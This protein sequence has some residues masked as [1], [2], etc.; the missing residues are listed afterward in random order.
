LAKV[1]FQVEEKH[2]DLKTA[3]RGTIDVE[4]QERTQDMPPRM[5]E[6]AEPSYQFPWARTQAVMAGK[7]ALHAGDVAGGVSAFAAAALRSALHVTKSADRAL[8]R[9]LH[10]KMGLRHVKKDKHDPLPTATWHT[11]VFSDRSV[12]VLTAEGGAIAAEVERTARAVGSLIPAHSMRTDEDI[13]SNYLSFFV[14]VVDTLVSGTA[15]A[16]FLARFADHMREG[17]TSEGPSEGGAG[18]GG[19]SAAA[20]A[21]DSQEGSSITAGEWRNRLLE[22]LRV[23]LERDIP[24]D[25]S[26]QNRIGGGGKSSEWRARQRVRTLLFGESGHFRAKAKL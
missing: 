14:A 23:H 3:P 26:T 19:T 1:S 24:N 25:Y 15:Q 13:K 17:G 12:E 9:T 11:T 21:S 20:A 7:E 4:A 2:P 6:A 18:G 5:T 10:R 16:T 8:L 22:R